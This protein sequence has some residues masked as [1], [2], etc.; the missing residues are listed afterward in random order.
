[1]FRKI[2]AGKSRVWV[3]VIV[4]MFVFAVVFVVVFAVV[5]MGVVSVKAS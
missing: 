5:F 2:E 4:V 1:M 3:V